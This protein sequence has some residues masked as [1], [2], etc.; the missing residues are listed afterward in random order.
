MVQDLSFEIGR[1]FALAT[2][3]MP[4][5][6]IIT[7]RKIV[8][9]INCSAFSKDIFNLLSYSILNFSVFVFAL[10]I[11]KIWIKIKTVLF[12]LYLENI[13]DIIHIIAYII[14][15]F[16]LPILI[17]III[18]IIDRKKIIKNVLQD[19]FGCSVDN[20][21]LTAWEELPDLERDASVTVCL[22]NGKSL[23]GIL[24]PKSIISSD[25]VNKD[26]YIS[27]LIEFDG[28]PINEEK[29]VWV[30]GKDISAII[31][32]NTQ[33]T[34]SEKNLLY[35][36]IKSIETFRYDFSVYVQHVEDKEKRENNE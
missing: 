13:T 21:I 3:F 16:A 9:P 8:T 31:F 34:N 19:K 20:G 26:I 4:A 36:I 6:V 22:R 23:K 24:A 7:L 27:R 1:Y 15:V 33:N 32:S 18:C 29:R 10:L 5:I 14:Y 30:N 28:Q 12:F 11:L 25:S 17:G 2:F 35:E